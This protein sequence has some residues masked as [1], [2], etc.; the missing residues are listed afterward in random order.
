MERVRWCGKRGTTRDEI[1]RGGTKMRRPDR[2]RPP[3]NFND[4]FF[5]AAFFLAFF[6]A[7]IIVSFKVNL[8]IV[9]VRFAVRTPDGRFSWSDLRLCS[10]VPRNK[11]A[12]IARGATILCHSQKK[13]QHFC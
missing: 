4:Y 12:K 5:F 11:I 7:A 9:Q 13:M 10:I 1:E 8:G 3:H 2:I 6:F